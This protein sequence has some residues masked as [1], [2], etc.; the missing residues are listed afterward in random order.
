MQYL[1]RCDC[2]QETIK[3]SQP[4]KLGKSTSCG[5]YRR[6]FSSEQHTKHGQA[7]VKKGRSRAY[8]VWAAMH[9]RCRNENSSNYPD[10]GGRGITVCER[11]NKYENFLEDMGH[12]P[13]GHTI[14]RESNNGNYEPGN[15]RWATPKEQALNRR[16]C[17]IVTYSGHKMPLSEAV[18]RS[19]TNV[20]YKIVRQ[21]MANNGW[22]LEEALFKPIRRKAA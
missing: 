1:C 6:E 4:L 21:R 15:C 19:E 10:Y 20:P 9:Q 16:S 13:T 14:D 2:G 22:P 12:P 3:T 5:C 7:S 11:W 8:R 17:R 18:E